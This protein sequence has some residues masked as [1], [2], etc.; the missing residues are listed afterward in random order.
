[1]TPPNVDGAPKPTSSVKIRS[2]FGAPAGAATAAG[3][4]EGLSF[5]FGMIVPLKGGV[6][7]GSTRLLGNSTAFCAPGVPRSCACAAVPATARDA[8]PARNLRPPGW[9]VGSF[10]CGASLLEDA[11]LSGALLLLV[12]IHLPLRVRIF[13]ASFARCIGIRDGSL[14]VSIG[15]AARSAQNCSFSPQCHRSRGDHP[16]TA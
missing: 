11:G 9:N 4:P 2:T 6:G 10:A 12:I 15:S 8:A 14:K 1:M 16:T 13:I 7:V 3:P 5:A